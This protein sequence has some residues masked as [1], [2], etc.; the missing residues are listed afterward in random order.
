[1]K[2]RMLKYLLMCLGICLLSSSC[3]DKNEQN[4]VDDIK[5]IVEEPTLPL[6]NQ[7]FMTGSTI[8]YTGVFTDN[9]K[10]KEAVFNLSKLKSSN[11]I[12]DPAWSPEQFKVALDGKSFTLDKEPIFSEDVP[13]AEPGYYLLSVYCEDYAGNKSEAISVQIVLL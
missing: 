8:V 7:E 11:G 2:I 13:P 4:P 9:E 10:L 5:P 1:M 3:K 12:G 6:L